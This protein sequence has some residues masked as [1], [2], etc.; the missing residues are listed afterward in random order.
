V[1]SLLALACAR[2]RI[3]RT[4]ERAL[5]APEPAHVANVAG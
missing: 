3:Y 5:R 1:T 4:L 2:D